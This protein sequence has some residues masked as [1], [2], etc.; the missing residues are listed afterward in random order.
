MNLDLEIKYSTSP[1]GETNRRCPDI[2]KMKALGY[3][4]KINL[5]SGL[6]LV[7]E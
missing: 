3:S 6:K 1:E 2:S 5:D 4:P 7:V